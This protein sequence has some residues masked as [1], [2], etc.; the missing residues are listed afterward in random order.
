MRLK[1]FRAPTL[2]IALGQVR[3]TFGGDALI[4][5]TRPVP[6]GVE[7]TAAADAD[8]D[9]PPKLPDP[10]RV[11]ALRYHGVP[12]ALYP[13]LGHGPLTEA[14]CQVIDFAPLPLG[15]DDPPL[16]FV[17]PPGA[18]K[19]L[20]TVRLAT[21]LTMAGTPPLVITADGQRAGA[22]EQLAAF[23]KLLRINLLVANH[24]VTLARAI[25]RRRGEPALID[26]PGTDPYARQDAA[27]LR[28]LA[29]AASATMILV[30]PAGLDPG[31]A[32]ELAFAYAELGARS[33][34]VTRLDVTRRIG[35]VVA[36]AAAV[37]LPLTEAG[38]GPDAAGGLVAITPEFLAARILR[39]GAARHDADPP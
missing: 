7:V 26:G 34:I 14:L 23:T 35:A 25:A 30:L 13:T 18:G 16:L 33:L 5:G 32:V 21:R 38:I 19:T 11:E 22:T 15:A 1:L 8:A 28:A 27:D 6:D 39:N 20:T 17:G 29:G 4:L 24:P 37:R 12:E 3:R 9:P 36:A 10:G 2:D 31:E